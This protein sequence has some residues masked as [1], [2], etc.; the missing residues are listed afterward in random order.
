MNFLSVLYAKAGI[1]VDG[2]TELNN[3]ATALTPATNDN[4]TKI[5]TTAFVKNQR[6]I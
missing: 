3:T 6:T 1:T 2:V 5:A 4:S